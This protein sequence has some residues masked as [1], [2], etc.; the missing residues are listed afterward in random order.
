MMWSFYHGI[1]TV[2]LEKNVLCMTPIYVSTIVV[3]LS[4]RCVHGMHEQGDRKKIYK[5][6]FF[7]EG[8]CG[9]VVTNFISNLC[10]VSH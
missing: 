10:R 2:C 5:V 8:R 3:L 6:D 9:W 1:V 7:C 4:L